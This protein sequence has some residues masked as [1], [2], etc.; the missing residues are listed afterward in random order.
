[1]HHLQNIVVLWKSNKLLHQREERRKKTTLRKSSGT[2]ICVNST[3]IRQLPS[4]LSFISLMFYVPVEALHG[5]RRNFPHK[6]LRYRPGVRN[7]IVRDGASSSCQSQ[8]RLHHRQALLLILKEFQADARQRKVRSTR[9]WD[10]NLDNSFHN[11]VTV[12]S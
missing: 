10:R 8:P 3:F 2:T 5:A 7:C 1:M 12:M 4:Y 9:P 6:S 11:R